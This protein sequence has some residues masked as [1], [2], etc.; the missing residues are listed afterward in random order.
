MQIIIYL[1]ITTNQL[2]TPIM[3]LMPIMLREQTAKRRIY[4]IKVEDLR[5]YISTFNE[6]ADEAGTIGMHHFFGIIPIMLLL[7]KTNQK[8]NIENE[9]E[10]L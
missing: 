8:I 9:L 6:L 5:N 7:S 2:N 3:T 4:N 10:I 1:K